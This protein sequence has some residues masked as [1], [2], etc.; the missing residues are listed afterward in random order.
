[1]MVDDDAHPIKALRAISRHRVANNHAP[2]V[3]E[4]LRARNFSRGSRGERM[5]D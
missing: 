4:F 3:P 5:P 2:L 1:M